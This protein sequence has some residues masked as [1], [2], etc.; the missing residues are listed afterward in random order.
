MLH[1]GLKLQCDTGH[2]C[3]HT[4]NLIGLPLSSVTNLSLRG[5]GTQLTRSSH[6]QLART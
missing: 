5:T 6:K 1:S 2:T 3:R 4:S